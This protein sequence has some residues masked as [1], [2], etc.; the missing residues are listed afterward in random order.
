MTY[1]ELGTLIACDPDEARGRAIEHMLD[2][3][4][5]RDGQTRVKLNRPLASLFLAMACDGVLQ[6]RQAHHRVMPV[7]GP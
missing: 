5:S 1:A 7:A 3:R 4:K 2:R 6:S